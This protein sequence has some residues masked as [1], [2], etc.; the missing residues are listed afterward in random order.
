M[1]RET[2]AQK[3]AQLENKYSEINKQIE[4]LMRERATVRE[5]LFALGAKPRRNPSALAVLGIMDSDV[6]EGPFKNN[7]ITAMGLNL[8]ARHLDDAIKPVLKARKTKK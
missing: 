7:I 4:G 8:Y 1:K 2:K 6:I 3:I 5:E